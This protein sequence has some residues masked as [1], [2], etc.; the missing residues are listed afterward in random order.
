MGINLLAR[1]GRLLE[2]YNWRVK[3]RRDGSNEANHALICTSL[4]QRDY[5][6]DDDLC[7]G[8]NSSRAGT[9]DSWSVTVHITF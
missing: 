8:K 3:A 7:E 9:L 2:A 4:M 1:D 5:I 6:G